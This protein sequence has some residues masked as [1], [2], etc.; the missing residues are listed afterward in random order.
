MRLMIA[1]ALLTQPTFLFAQ[2]TI[3]IGSRLELMIDDHL[4]DGMSG[5]ARLQLNMPVRREVALVTDSP[6]EGNACHYR[7]VFQDGDRYRMYYR[8]ANFDEDKPPPTTAYQNRRPPLVCYAE[9]VDGIH[10]T[11]PILGLVEVNGSTKNNVV[12]PPT[13]QLMADGS[14]NGSAITSDPSGY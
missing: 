2:Q 3:D 8:A 6:W 13:D 5:G 9:S 1:V 4:I 7:S 10:W 14:I 12:W 11:R